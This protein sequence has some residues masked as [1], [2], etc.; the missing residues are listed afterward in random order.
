MPPPRPPS[1]TSLLLVVGA[2]GG[3]G[4]SLVAGA[5]A[6]A[7]AR[8]G[9]GVWLVE[10]DLDRGD[11]GDAWELAHERTLADLVGVAGEIDAAHLRHAV[12]D[13][14]GGVRVLLASATPGSAAAWGTE[15][16]G[17]LLAAARAAAG[18]TG[19]VVVD[20]GVGLS[21]S[22]LAAA[23]Q[24]DGI[25]IVCSPAVAAA[26]R[27]RRL[28]ESLASSDAGGRCALVVNHGAANGEISARSLGRAVGAPVLAELPWSVEEGGRLVAG[29]WPAG[30]RRRLATAVE[31][32]AGAIA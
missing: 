16:V 3:A 11:R 7:W 12:H 19:R 20:G 14:G 15:A 4:A 8:G 27:A 1:A 22:S 21:I 10:L 6:L 30:R 25:L 31:G 9:C 32:L 17:R 26:R 23:A 18:D 29:R 24:A 13:H 2:N 5:L 28:V